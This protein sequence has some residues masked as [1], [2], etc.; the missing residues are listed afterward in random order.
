MLL[1]LLS[2]QLFLDRLFFCAVLSYMKLFSIFLNT[3]HVFNS[4]F[5]FSILFYF[6]KLQ[7]NEAT[8]IHLSQLKPSEKSSSAIVFSLFPSWSLYQL[9]IKNYLF[10]KFLEKEKCKLEQIAFTFFE[11]LKKPELWLRHLHAS[12]SSQIF[13]QIRPFFIFFFNIHQ[14]LLHS[15]FYFVYVFL[16]FQDLQS[17]E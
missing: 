5:N 2:K 11:S 10:C 13:R 15:P 6:K 9:F 3:L 1:H 14:F 8:K 16:F 12:K 7:E 4:V 17:T